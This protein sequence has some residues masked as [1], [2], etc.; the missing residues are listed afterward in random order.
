M[1]KKLALLALCSACC[2]GGCASDPVTTLPLY[3]ALGVTVL[4]TELETGVATLTPEEIVE[5]RKIMNAVVPVTEQLRDLAIAYKAALDAAPLQ[6]K[7]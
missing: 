2:L 7:K 4:K 5:R 1:R 3:S 6:K